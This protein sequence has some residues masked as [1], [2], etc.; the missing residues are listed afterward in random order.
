MFDRDKRIGP[1]QYRLSHGRM[2]PGRVYYR[3]AVLS[4]PVIVSIKDNAGEVCTSPSCSSANNYEH[5]KA[6]PVVFAKFCKI[7]SEAAERLAHVH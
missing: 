1:R 2:S 3:R 6:S 4:M 5:E 7:V